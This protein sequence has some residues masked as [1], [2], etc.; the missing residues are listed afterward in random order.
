MP[1]SYK[2]FNLSIYTL[3][4]KGSLLAFQRAL[5]DSCEPD[6]QHQQ[7]LDNINKR[8]CTRLNIN[9]WKNTASVIE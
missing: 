3:S 6:Y 1:K 5:N 8:L 9:Q 2:A 7:K 4:G